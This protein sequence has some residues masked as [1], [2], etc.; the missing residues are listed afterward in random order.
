[1][2]ILQLESEVHSSHFSIENMEDRSWWKE[3]GLF[4]AGSEKD[5]RD[6]SV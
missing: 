4:K 5:G 3:M 6:L 1:L 2:V